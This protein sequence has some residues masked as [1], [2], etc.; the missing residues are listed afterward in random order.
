[1]AEHR[2]TRILINAA[3][4]ILEVEQPMTVRQLFYRLV[5]VG[6]IMNTRQ[7]YQRVSVVMTT[8]REDGRCPFEYIVD[9]SRP[10]YAP[11]VFT[12]AAE[13]G[14]T[15][16]NAYRKDYWSAQPNHVEVWVEKDAVI[17]SI[18]EVTNDLGVTV[19]V[20][21]GFLSTTRTYEIA[22]H[23]SRIDKP[24]TVFYLGDHDPSGHDIERDLQT[25]I[26]KQSTRL[27]D[28]ERLA[29]F[30]RDIAAFGL[31]P[32]RLKDA[33]PRARQFRQEHGTECVELDALPPTEL[34]RRIT[35]AIYDLI[36]LE[37]WGRAIAVEKVE[38]ASIQAAVASWPRAAEQS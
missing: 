10:E 2:K 18:Q 19:R 22:Q 24:I 6:H 26:L 13:Y 30:A 8:A 33:D 7:E 9:R 36:D 17:G 12:D 25:R 11:N 27:F 31:P 32:L 14:R 16:K 4:A 37:L 21:R 35:S 38:L 23:F 34:R 20:G 5:S 28:V 3:L 15:V 1:M 29:I